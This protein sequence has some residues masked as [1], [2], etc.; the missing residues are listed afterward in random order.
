MCEQFWSSSGQLHSDMCFAEIGSRVE[1][2]YLEASNDL[3]DQTYV[4]DILVAGQDRS[5][6]SKKTSEIDVILGHAGM[7]AKDWVLS[8]DRG[9]E[10]AIGADDDSSE[11]V[12]GISWRP[13][14][15]T[16]RFQVCLQMAGREI[17]SLNEFLGV[18]NEVGLSRRVVLSNVSRIFDPIGLL[19]PVLLTSKLLMR[20]SWCGSSNG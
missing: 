7:P 5:C 13:E 4:D 9:T 6:L 15:D 8:G 18:V 2:T 12:L 11:K 10:V 1:K 20:E 14:S 16:F 3:V 19:N 17:S